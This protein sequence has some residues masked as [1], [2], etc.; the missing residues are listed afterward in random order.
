MRCQWQAL[1]GFLCGLQLRGQNAD[2]GKL[3]VGAGA[4]WGTAATPRPNENA[5]V[6]LGAL[7]FLAGVVAGTSLADF[8]I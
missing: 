6:G 7:S 8:E 5:L 1:C 2:L 4:G 3:D